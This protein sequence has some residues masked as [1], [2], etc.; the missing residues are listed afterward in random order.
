MMGVV[1]VGKLIEALVAEK[2]VTVDGGKTQPSGIVRRQRQQF[3]IESNEMRDHILRP[4]F[5][6][7]KCPVDPQVVASDAT[8]PSQLDRIGEKSD[9][10]EERVQTVIIWTD[11]INNLEETEQLNRGEAW[12]DGFSSRGGYSGGNDNGNGYRPGGF[13]PEKWKHELYQEVNRD[14]TP[15]N[16]DDI[17]VV[18]TMAMDISKSCIKAWKHSCLV[19]KLSNLHGL[20]CFWCYQC[21][22]K[23]FP[24]INGLCLFGTNS[25]ADCKFYISSSIKLPDN[26]RV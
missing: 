1:V 11:Q 12:R 9:R 4:A 15:S 23:L 7:K 6:E 13:R 5:W 18:M 17:M 3:M 19:G 10:R 21:F 16:E 22:H 14:P 25:S 24:S 20:S 8:K 2:P 26:Q